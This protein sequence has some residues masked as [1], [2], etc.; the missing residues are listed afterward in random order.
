MHG[1][2]W[3]SRISTSGDGVRRAANRG[4]VGQPVCCRGGPWEISS[5]L[6]PFRSLVGKFA[7]L[8]R[9]S[10]GHG[11]SYSPAFWSSVFL[12]LPREDGSERPTVSM[13]LSV[14]VLSSA[15]SFLCFIHLLRLRLS[16]FSPIVSFSD[17]AFR[18]AGSRKKRAIIQVPRYSAHWDSIGP[19]TCCCRY[20]HTSLGV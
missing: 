10:L 2:R 4:T 1:L 20:L 14:A 3:S 13:Y 9:A 6:S 17:L 5:L 16:E 12:F 15:L 18:P 11:W 7:V 8:L 19:G